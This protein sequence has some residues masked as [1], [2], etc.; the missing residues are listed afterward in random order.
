MSLEFIKGSAEHV[1]YLLSGYGLGC[2]H[3]LVCSSSESEAQT[4]TSRLGFF[5]SHNPDLTIFY[6]DT[7]N[8]CSDCLRLAAPDGFNFWS[9]LPNPKSGSGKTNNPP[10]KWLSPSGQADGSINVQKIGAV[11]SEISHIPLPSSVEGK[12]AWEWIKSQQKPFYID[13]LYLAPKWSPVNE[14]NALADSAIAWQHGI[15]MPLPTIRPAPAAEENQPVEA[16]PPKSKTSLASSSKLEKSSGSTGKPKRKKVQDPELQADTTESTGLALSSNKNSRDV[17]GSTDN[18]N[19]KKP[20]EAELQADATEVK[21]ASSSTKKEPKILASASEPV[22]TAQSTGNDAGPFSNKEVP[23]MQDEG[24]T[25]EKEKLVRSKRIKA[26]SPRHEESTSVGDPNM[27]RA[28]SSPSSSAQSVPSIR[29]KLAATA[30]SSDKGTSQVSEGD[31]RSAQKAEKISSRPKEAKM[32]SSIRRKPVGVT[33]KATSSVTVEQPTTTNVVPKIA[34]SGQ[35][36]KL[37]S[38]SIML[39]LSQSSPAEKS[40]KIKIKSPREEKVKTK[41]TSA[42]NTKEVVA[43]SKSEEASKLKTSRIAPTL[44]G[45]IKEAKPKAVSKKEVPHSQVTSTATYTRSWYNHD[46]VSFDEEMTLSKLSDYKR[47]AR[48]ANI[49][50]ET[51]PQLPL[52]KFLR[53]TQ[54]LDKTKKLSDLKMEK[55]QKKDDPL[56]AYLAPTI[57]DKTKSKLPLGSAMGMKSIL[58]AKTFHERSKINKVGSEK[59]STPLSSGKNPLGQEKNFRLNSINDSHKPKPDTA[60]PSKL[61]TETVQD[62]GNIMH[63]LGTQSKIEKL[64]HS[65]EDKLSS[66]DGKGPSQRKKDT[67][68]ET[69]TS[70]SGVPPK[71]SVSHG[72]HTSHTSVT[73]H[74]HRHHE[75]PKKFDIHFEDRKKPHKQPEKKPQKR[76]DK[77][78][79][80]KSPGHKPHDHRPHKHRPHDSQPSGHWPDGHE[81]DGKP[82]NQTSSQ[83]VDSNPSAVDST[84]NNQTGTDPSPNIALTNASTNDPFPVPNPTANHTPAPPPVAQHLP[85]SPNVPDAPPDDGGVSTQESEI[86][87]QLPTPAPEIPGSGNI[88]SND[89]GPG[90]T[91]PG[92]STDE[93]G[94]QAEN[95]VT[96]STAAPSPET[97][98]SDIKPQLNVEVAVG[99]STT[100]LTTGTYATTTKPEPGT[101]SAM[102]MSTATLTSVADPSNVKPEPNGPNIGENNPT[103]TIS[104]NEPS[105]GV[106]PDSG[107]AQSYFEQS[108]HESV[109]TAQG[110]ATGFQQYGQGP[111]SGLGEKHKLSGGEQSPSPLPSTLS[112]S[113]IGLVA[114]V[115]LVGAATLAGTI[116]AA[117]DNMSSG[118]VSGENSGHE[119]LHEGDTPGYAP[120]DDFN[121]QFGHDHSD[122]ERTHSV[123]SHLSHCES[124]ASQP[125]FDGD[126][127]SQ[128]GGD[129]HLIETPAD[130]SEASDIET[131]P[132]EEHQVQYDSDNEVSSLPEIQEYHRQDYSSEVENH[133]EAAGG[134]DDN[135]IH[136]DSEEHGGHE[137]H[138]S[139]DHEEHTSDNHSDAGLSHSSELEELDQDEDHEPDINSSDHELDHDLD[140]DLDPG[141]DREDSGQESNAIYEESDQNSDN[142]MDQNSDNDIDQNDDQESEN[143]LDHQSDVESDQESDLDSDHIL[144]DED[145]PESEP[146][147]DPEPDS[148]DRESLQE[149]EPEQDSDPET[150]DDEYGSD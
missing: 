95:S 37:A 130:L 39:L 129:D 1:S 4:Y 68:L 41:S 93:P 105:T 7:K 64:S 104:D 36:R 29:K 77:N 79:E 128:F 94:A 97:N 140:Q 76:P 107:A 109:Q 78:P 2:P 84:D 49:S 131:D 115:G 127:V 85:T 58:E 132:V 53:E 98:V 62:F 54:P 148:S 141:S 145:N 150:G 102:V 100:G 124:D 92:S 120:E 88:Q 139:N 60:L 26:T 24:I 34:A 14:R 101:D 20:R 73:Y 126:D 117:D 138:T 18:P 99:N 9:L 8:I 70:T 72:R 38:D 40:V 86:E 149:A 22:V 91:L 12:Y 28:V 125:A 44:E 25:S 81:S 143:A 74:E 61:L 108:M 133:N 35:D 50:A 11:V 147:S 13:Q 42:S 47:R 31:M 23:S 96:S 3:Y 75:P 82:G 118:I 48:T 146:E 46:P 136:Y 90:N 43:G 110:Q 134:N 83:L 63:K 89:E 144:E 113:G 15:S 111:G 135:T 121:E 6:T 57:K 66:H 65:L 56:M 106:A 87:Q 30:Q 19:R 33:S 10:R 112:T 16:D 59:I 32:V 45:A 52:E 142:D 116:T 80:S 17:V 123:A 55:T 103:S 51:A 67:R 69:K 114:G 137:E 5:S 21:A 119:N 27:E 122:D 71:S